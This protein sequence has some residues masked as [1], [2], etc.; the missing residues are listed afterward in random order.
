LGVDVVDVRQQPGPGHPVGD[1]LWW[2]D[3]AVRE[4]DALDADAA[5]GHDE[6]SE[7]RGGGEHAD[8]A[9]LMAP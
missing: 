5:G 1:G 7:L 3:L 4:P 6:G 9:N 8:V 2:D